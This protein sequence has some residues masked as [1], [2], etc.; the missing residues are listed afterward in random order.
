MTGPF[1]RDTD[2]LIEAVRTA[3]RREILPRF[4]A[5]EP[6]DIRAKSSAD[7]LVTIADERAEA[8][9]AEA[10]RAI[11][12]AAAIVGEEAVSAD[13]TALEP[14][15]SAETCVVIDPVDGTWNFV[16]GLATFGVIVAVLRRGTT[17]FGLLYDPLND[18]WVAA[19]RGG[20]AWYWRPGSAPQ[21]LAVAPAGPMGEAIGYVP[22]SL[23]AQ[24][25]QAAVA[26]ALPRFAHASSLRC[27]CHEYRMLAMGHAAFC[28]SPA[29]KPWDHAAGALAVVEAGGCAVGADASPYRVDDVDAPLVVAS[30]LGLAGEVGET[31]GLRSTGAVGS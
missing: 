30:N 4:R 12:P 23:F 10:A 27:S 7:D 21:R 20:G 1:A 28:V 14:L 29:P 22:L 8:A 19:H 17:D 6:G 9:I 16:H 31:L 5:L 15:A 26:A 11:W 3:A 13:P 2:A 18:D 24:S 25:E